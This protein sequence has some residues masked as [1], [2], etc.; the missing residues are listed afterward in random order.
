MA[1]REFIFP[2]WIRLT[3]VSRRSRRRSSDRG[4]L[5]QTGTFICGAVGLDTD[6]TYVYQLFA[7]MVCILIS[8]RISLRFQI[9]EVSVRRQLPRY[10]TAGEPFEYY[11]NIVNEGS[12][13]ERDLSVMDNPEVVPPTFEEFRRSREPGEETR[14]AYDRWIGF[15]R[16]MWLQRLKTGINIKTARAPDVE[17]KS[18]AQARM[19]AT[20]LRRGIVRILST[21]VMHP[22]P[23]GLNYGIIEFY[24]PGHLTVLPRRYPVSRKFSFAG[25]RHFQPGGVNS[26]WSIGES[27]EF[28]S[29]RDYRDGDPIRKIH[30]ASSARRDKP[31]VKEFQDEFFVRQALVVDSLPQ[32]PEIYEEVI[33]VA[34][35]LLTAMENND[36][37]MDLCILADG[38][39]VITAGRG[40]SQTSQ[41]LEALATL[42]QSTDTREQEDLIEMLGQR[43]RLLSGCVFVF[44]GMDEQ[45][46]RLLEAV[47]QRGVQTAVFVVTAATPPTDGK[48]TGRVDAN[49]LSTLRSDFHQLTLGQ[50][51]EDL[52]AL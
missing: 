5:M 41:Q 12:R 19:E 49:G 36:G 23:L 17:L 39:Q 27:D 40:F 1:F 35:S 30:W 24:N 32:D 43:A 11:I 42:D 2:T 8:A 9:P 45:R 16:F 38:P 31:V 25:G 21:T 20:P 46:Q 50:V 14:N 33:S 29:L 4:R 52:A 10:A 48:E 44:A 26:T 7:L 51:A 47:E 13:V 15:H 37:L 6:L 28:V 22:D 3:N 34:A 18:T